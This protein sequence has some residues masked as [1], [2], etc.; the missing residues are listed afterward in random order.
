M[1]IIAV[2]LRVILPK[3]IQQCHTAQRFRTGHS[4]KSPLLPQTTTIGNAPSPAPS[5]AVQGFSSSSVSYHHL[6]RYAVPVTVRRTDSADERELLNRATLT[7][8]PVRLIPRTFEQ[9]IAQLEPWEEDLLR[10][11]RLL[12]DPRLTVLEL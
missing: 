12:V 5:W 10:R 8:Q 11:T 6:P 1:G 3:L 2:K 9:F 7:T 4:R